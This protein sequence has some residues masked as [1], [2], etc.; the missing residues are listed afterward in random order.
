MRERGICVVMCACAYAL[1]FEKVMYREVQLDFTPE[2]VVFY[3]L[4][5][6]CDTKNRKQSLKHH[7]K[8]F[9][10]RSQIQLDHPLG[11][12]K[13]CEICLTRESVW[14]RKRGPKALCNPPR[15]SEEA[16]S[17]FLRICT[18]P[19]FLRLFQRSHPYKDISLSPF[20][21]S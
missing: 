5:E 15:S 10:F 9:N 21:S 7:I 18:S 8:Y 17:A 11:S 14:L 4:F 1:R 13:P 16:L 3:T 12:M 6:R 19:P 2:I 20:G